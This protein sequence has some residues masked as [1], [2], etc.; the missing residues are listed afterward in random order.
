MISRE[1]SFPLVNIEA[2]AQGVP[3]LCFDSAGGTPEFIN[4]RAGAVVPYLDLVAMSDKILELLGDRAKRDEL[5]ANAK[6][7]S[8]K[9]TV[10]IIA[11]RVLGEIRKCANS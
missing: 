2:A 4:G 5:G 1:D 3:V 7:E 10:D 9:Y 8:G 6:K 11:K